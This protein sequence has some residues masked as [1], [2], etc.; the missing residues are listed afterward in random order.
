ML[1]ML[2]PTLGRCVHMQTSIPLVYGWQIYPELRSFSH[3]FGSIKS[4]I[5]CMELE[6]ELELEQRTSTFS[7]FYNAILTEKVP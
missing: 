1:W 7:M 5:L 3:K 2:R 4:K 6:L